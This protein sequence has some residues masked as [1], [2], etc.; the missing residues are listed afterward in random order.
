M[1]PNAQQMVG[2]YKDPEGEKIPFMSSVVERSI[3]GG[4][5]VKAL[6]GG[7]LSWNTTSG[8]V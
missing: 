1:L 7:L 2:L 5:E 6:R 4:N 3:G 8:N